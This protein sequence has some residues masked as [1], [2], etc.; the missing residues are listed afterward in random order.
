MHV[1]ADW[2]CTTA[3]DARVKLKSPDQG[4]LVGGTPIETVVGTHRQGMLVL[5]RC[6]SRRGELGSHPC[7]EM[8]SGWAWAFG[9][10]LP[11]AS[12]APAPTSDRCVRTMPGPT[13]ARSV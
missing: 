4:L 8:G 5:L 2:E 6:C 11:S 13:L 10:Y 3:A 1:K 9:A 7:C 12:P